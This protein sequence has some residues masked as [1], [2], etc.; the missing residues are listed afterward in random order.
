MVFSAKSAHPLRRNGF[1]FV[2]LNGG[3]SR[4]D[5]LFSPFCTFRKT[6]YCGSNVGQTVCA[7]HKQGEKVRKVPGFVMK[8]G[9]FLARR[10][11]FEPLRSLLLC[12][13]LRN[14]IRSALPRSKNAAHFGSG[15]R[16]RSSERNNKAPPV[17]GALLFGT[18]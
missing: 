12:S 5:F 18:P 4:P 1:R 11:G 3:F 15:V 17:G 10:K 8:P 9:T 6:S 7:C 13:L 14:L 16:I 2:R